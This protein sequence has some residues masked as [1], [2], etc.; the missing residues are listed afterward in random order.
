MSI[1][2]KTKYGE[3]TRQFLDKLD[4]GEMVP[5]HWL[6]YRSHNPRI[7]VGKLRARGHRFYSVTEGNHT[8]GWT[9]ELP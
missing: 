6:D 5:Y 7:F 1:T 8:V 9:K 2:I 4:S 3:I